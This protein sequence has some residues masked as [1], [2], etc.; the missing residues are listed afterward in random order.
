MIKGL[1]CDGTPK[2]VTR[3]CSPCGPR[4]LS[5]AYAMRTSGQDPEQC[6]G[7]PDRDPSLD[8]VVDRCV[9]CPDA[10]ADTII[11]PCGD[12]AAYCVCSKM[13]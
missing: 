1:M 9:V 10:L 11:P 13:M 5:K 7:L 3:L 2:P 4:V 12:Q 8:H 6:V